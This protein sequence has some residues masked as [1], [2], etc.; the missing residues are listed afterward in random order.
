[1]TREEPL[2]QLLERIIGEEGLLLYDAERH[3]V[4]SLRI[5]IAKAKAST[6]SAAE[7]GVCEVGSGVSSGDCSKVCRRLMVQ[8]EVDGPEFGLGTEPEI[9]VSSPGVNR[10]LRLPEHFQGAVGERVKVVCR[11]GALVAPNGKSHNALVGL[12][13]SFSDTGVV[14]SEESLREQITIPVDAIKKASVAFKF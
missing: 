10:E 13:E 5:T 3:G 9:E 4:N 6:A 1:M 11:A 7:D 14:I 2:W 12:L 8:F